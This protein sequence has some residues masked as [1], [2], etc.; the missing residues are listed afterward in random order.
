[1]LVLEFHRGLLP[2]A[3]AV[4]RTELVGVLDMARDGILDDDMVGTNDFRGPLVPGVPVGMLEYLRLVGRAD[5]V[6]DVLGWRLLVP[7]VT[8][9]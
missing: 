4:D 8:L 2:D 1:M 3:G 7:G 6:L 9:P 5:L